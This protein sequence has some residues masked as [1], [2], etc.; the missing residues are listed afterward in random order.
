MIYCFLD[1]ACRQSLNY[2]TGQ[3]TI[4]DSEIKELQKKIETAPD[5][6]KVQLRSFLQEAEE[7]ITELR[8][9]LETVEKL[10]QQTAD[11]FCED[12]ETFKLDV[13]L[14][15][16]YSFFQEFENAQKVCVYVDDPWIC[17]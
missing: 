7:D 13:C 15:E 6:L 5:D 17:D 10:S 14:A 11:Y 8:F 3:V 4:L 2:L 12:S 16:L 1:I 9:C